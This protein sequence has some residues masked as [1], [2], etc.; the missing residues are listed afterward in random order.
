M[1]ILKGENIGWDAFVK[2][3]EE[4]FT[5]VTSVHQKGQIYQF[6]DHFEELK[7]RLGIGNEAAMFLL[8]R[9]IKGN[10]AKGLYGQ[11]NV[12]DKYNDYVAA[13]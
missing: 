10:I 11:G 6:L 2:E 13:L 12:P 5:H 4:R 8:E 3:L 1:T 9:N 7:E